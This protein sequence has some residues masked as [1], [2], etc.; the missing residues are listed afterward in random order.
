V[1]KL[2][3]P[4]PPGG[5]VDP[6]ARVAQLGLQQKL[7]ATV[8]VE[9]KPGASGSIGAA[10]VAKAEPDGNTWLF[11]YE[12]QAI[13]PALMRL[14]FDS[15]K[16]LEPVQLIGTSPAILAKHP[17]R[18]WKNIQEL[19]TA[20]KDK[21]NS[22]SYASTGLGSIGHLAMTLLSD[23]A[24]IQLIHAP[25]RGGGPAIND[26]IAGHVD[27]V[28]GSV[29]L[30]QPHI[31]A[32]RLVGLLNFG[33]KR[34]ASMPDIPTAAE[35]GFAGLEAYAW[36]GVFAPKGTPQ[37]I[38]DRFAAALAETL[39]EDKKARGMFDSWQVGL[40]LGGP[41]EFRTF[42]AKQMKQ[43]GQVV[44]EHSIKG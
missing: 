33:N 31:K 43:W 44:A 19:I 13:N 30:T 39:R 6:I 29:A 10:E 40:R 9:N 42:F 23:K 38:V 1:I 11:A 7:G 17:S 41:Q 14:S 28:V 8:V 35:S 36:W 34:L 15:E 3:V 2:I 4:V 5:T 16:D 22:I 18:P 24:G 37:P 32:G 25:Y 27:S 12:T 26:A 20:A 21:P